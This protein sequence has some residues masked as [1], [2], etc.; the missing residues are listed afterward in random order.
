MI[1][2]APVI[3]V[4]HVDEL[5]LRLIDPGD[6]PMLHDFVREN[7]AHLQDFQS[8]VARL[9]EAPERAV[10]AVQYS[11][12]ALATGRFLQYRVMHAEEMAGTVT[13]FDR[14]TTA[15]KVGYYIGKNFIGQGFAPRAARALIEYA[16]QPDVWGLTQVD[17]QIADSNVPSHHV[18]Q[19]LG[20]QPTMSYGSEETANGTR[21]ALRVWEMHI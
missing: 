17:L 3:P 13:L 5:E 11:I 21:R 4:P 16:K 12:A 9:G 1:E 15:A 14:N 8:Q 7:Q 10:A 18:A 20:A 19:R 6:A 2:Y